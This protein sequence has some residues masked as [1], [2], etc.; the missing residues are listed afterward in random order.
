MVQ[1]CG[2][3]LRAATR[4]PGGARS[5]AACTLSHAHSTPQTQEDRDLKE[6][7]DLAVERTSDILPEIQR[8][9]IE[10][11]RKEIRESTR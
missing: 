10:V 4:A 7:L 6:R 3:Q 9:A 1:P 11:L 5:E 8:N 2:V